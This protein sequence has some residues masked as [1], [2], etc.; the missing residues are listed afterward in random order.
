MYLRIQLSR[1][2]TGRIKGSFKRFVVMNQYRFV[3]SHSWRFVYGSMRHSILKQGVSRFQQNSSKRITHS[4]SA[5]YS[6]QHVSTRWLLHCLKLL[7]YQWQ[8]QSYPHTFDE[9]FLNGCFRGSNMMEESAVFMVWLWMGLIKRV[10]TRLSNSSFNGKSESN[11]LFDTT[12][13]GPFGDWVNPCE[14]S[15]CVI[16]PQLL[17]SPLQ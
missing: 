14:F 4:C 2:G 10:Q 17:Y 3:S 11:N 13:F 9:T 16:V 15:Q 8:K 12:N 1:T 6:F 7:R 5:L